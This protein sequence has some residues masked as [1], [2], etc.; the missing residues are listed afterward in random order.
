MDI[1]KITNK[2]NNKIYIGKSQEC[3]KQR[4]KEHTTSALSGS[5]KCPKL[6]NA[7]RKYGIENFICEKIDER[8]TQRELCLCEQY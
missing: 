1:Y 4:F 3:Y 7:M 5:T 2:I 8:D 6:Y